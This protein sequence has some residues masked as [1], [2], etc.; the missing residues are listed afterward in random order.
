MHIE[1]ARNMT[2]EERDK[3]II[4]IKNKYRLPDNCIIQDNDL[5]IIKKIGIIKIQRQEGIRY[6]ITNMHVGT[7]TTK[8]GSEDSVY[9]VGKGTKYNKKGLGVDQ[10]TV[11][12]SATPFN[13]SFS[14][15]LEVAEAR[16]RSRVVLE[17]A[18]L[19]GFM[20]ADELNLT[21]EKSNH[22]AMSENDS[23]IKAALEK[24]EKR[25]L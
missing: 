4:K 23:L 10:I 15:K 14:Y 5:V 1:I 20:G 13:T 9:L 21:A 16:L 12:A 24:I 2:T 17:L 7:I 8:I 25:G 18:G 22:P 19:E 6:D 11:T 3:L